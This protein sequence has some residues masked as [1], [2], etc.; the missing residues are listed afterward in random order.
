ME[1]AL[2]ASRA[3]QCLSQV[4]AEH[5]LEEN[6]W[7]PETLDTLALEAPPKSWTSREWL[8][9]R[10]DGQR[11]VAD[12][13]PLEQP[14]TEEDAESSMAQVSHPVFPLYT[15]DFTSFQIFMHP[16]T[17]RTSMFMPSIMSPISPFSAS[18]YSL[19]PSSPYEISP[20][21]SQSSTTSSLP[22]I[23]E[24]NIPF[25]AFKQYSYN[26][27]QQ[28][29]VSPLD[30]F[31][32]PLP[33]TEFDEAMERESLA[34]TTEASSIT[35]TQDETFHEHLRSKACPPHPPPSRDVY[36][37]PCSPAPHTSSLL[38]D[39]RSSSSYRRQRRASRS[40]APYTSPS[41][42]VRPSAMRAASRN[43][44][45]VDE[46]YEEDDGEDEEDGDE[47]EYN[48]MSNH[49]ITSSH[50]TK[51]YRVLSSSP[52]PTSSQS[53]TKFPHKFNCEFCLKLYTRKTD[54]TRHLLTCKQNPGA[55][56]KKEKVNCRYC[57]AKAPGMC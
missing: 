35:Q 16:P 12:P 6:V 14:N 10:D 17:P 1:A 3:S 54:V 25:D 19:S 50:P 53:E 4:I 5:S 38:V 49:A 44:V 23:W 47:D 42:D 15:H 27:I 8:D 18:D 31:P 46:D 36:T 11:E 57:G 41:P 22:G 13:F 51:K 37:S 40:T 7:G 48:P 26:D 28:G 24:S 45:V 43:A 33:I 20:F 9:L 56:G 52:S 2:L 21:S 29:T 55:V 30:I 39:T 34:L 32:R